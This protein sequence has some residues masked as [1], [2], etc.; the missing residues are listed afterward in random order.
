MW[1]DGVVAMSARYKKNPLV[2]G[3]DLK[4]EIRNDTMNNMRVEWGTGTSN[5]WRLAST[6]C[7]NALLKEAPYQLVFIEGMSL[8]TKLTVA[9]D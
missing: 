5:D 6:N 9:R 8:A 4:N 7:A 2:I 1:Q 3:H